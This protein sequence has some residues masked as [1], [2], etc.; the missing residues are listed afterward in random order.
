[1]SREEFVRMLYEEHF[2]TVFKYCLPK[3]GFD[4]DAAADC[5]HSVFDEAEK[6]FEKL[7]S[8]PNRLGWLMTTAKHKLHKAWRKS[9]RESS[10]NLPIELA[11]A[12]PDARD[13]FDAVELTDEDVKEITAAVLSGL[14]ENELEIYRLFFTE[15][16]SFAETADRLGITEKAARAR[17]ARVKV[18]LRNRLAEFV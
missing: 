17:L 10:R 11:C 1:M 13:P 7:L 12:V 3:L 9:S 15:N 5:A 4:E 16:L 14:K 18:K 2:D 8:H 6:K